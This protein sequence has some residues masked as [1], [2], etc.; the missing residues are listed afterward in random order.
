MII[1][2]SILKTHEQELSYFDND[3]NLRINEKHRCK[4]EPKL[5][6]FKFEEAYKCI[7]FSLHTFFEIDYKPDYNIIN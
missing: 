5:A 7:R 3:S 1:N 2:Y 4:N 6:E